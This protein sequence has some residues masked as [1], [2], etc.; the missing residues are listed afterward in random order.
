M[1]ARR[2]SVHRTA[3]LVLVVLTATAPALAQDVTEV[4]LKGAF[5]LNFA[6]F[7]DWPPESSPTGSS[8]A[9]CVVGD[10]AVA[11]SFA[12]AAQG[13]TPNGRTIVVSAIEPNV[14]LPACHFV[15]LSGMTRTRVA[16]ILGTFR[17]KAIL[18]VS[19]LEG[20]AGMGGVVEVGVEAGKMKFRLNPHAAKRAHIQIS[21]RLLAL[22]EL[23]DDAP[24]GPTAPVR[25]V[26][27]IRTNRELVRRITDYAIGW[28]M[29]FAAGRWQQ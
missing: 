4:T 9:A 25:P 6:R 29:R 13:R 27:P 28:P 22:A 23:V 3:V 1:S 19:D 11:E 7:A 20:F 12:R 15:Y 24:A 2:L 17:E 10:H 16:E 8:L 18:T 5:L 21:S 26:T 14:A